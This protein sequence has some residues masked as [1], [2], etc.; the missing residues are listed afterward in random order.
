MLDIISEQFVLSRKDEPG[1]YGDAA[2]DFFGPRAHHARAV[3][4]SNSS[5]SENSSQ[6]ESMKHFFARSS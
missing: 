1:I 6:N 4:H 3:G 2:A 5:E